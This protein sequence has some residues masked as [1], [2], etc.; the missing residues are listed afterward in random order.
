MV[1]DVGTLERQVRI[2][3]SHPGSACSDIL[4]A[5]IIYKLKLNESTMTIPPVP[6]DGVTSGPSHPP[7]RNCGRDLVILLLK[8]MTSPCQWFV[9]VP[10]NCVKLL[11]DP[12]GCSHDT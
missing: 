6:L 10:I 12:A 5:V 2:P 11:T 4:F 9:C 3:V 7:D 1:A 8:T